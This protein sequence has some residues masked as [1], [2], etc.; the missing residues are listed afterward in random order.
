MLLA[1]LAMVEEEIVYL[2]GKV[3]EL[4]L[5][6]Y[7]EGKQTEELK[8]HHQER[9]L[10]RRRGRFFRRL[11][12]TKELE[13]ALHQPPALDRNSRRR[14][15]MIRDRQ[16]PLGSISEA[17]GSGTIPPISSSNLLITLS[18]TVFALCPPTLSSRVRHRELQ[19][20][21]MAKPDN[22][23]LRRGNL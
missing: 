14:R 17:T 8:L 21:L 3:K 4:R 2:E 7:E 10:R 18:V 11:S 6:L 19:T 1:E 5:C 22:C 12:R 20:I 15:R 9:W 23:Q 13:E 16:M